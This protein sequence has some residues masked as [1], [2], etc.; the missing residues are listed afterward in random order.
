MIDIRVNGHYPSQR[1]ISDSMVDI[2][3]SGRNPS[4][5]SISESAVKYPSQRP[6]SESTANIR[7]SGR[8]PS[9]WS[10]SE[11]VVDIRVNGQ[12]PSQRYKGC[13]RLQSAHRKSSAC[14][15]RLVSDRFDR[16]TVDKR[17]PALLPSPIRPRNHCA[18][19]TP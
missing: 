8:D 5:R 15:R 11:S 1:S 13:S 7:V 6:I 18:R 19:M 16:R 12:Y 4:Q 3:V 10:I 14:G 2:R 17:V 9:Q